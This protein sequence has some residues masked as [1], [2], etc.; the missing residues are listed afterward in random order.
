MSRRIPLFAIQSV[1]FI[2]STRCFAEIV[3]YGADD[4]A[5]SP[6]PP[7]ELSWA[8]QAE[9]TVFP[10]Y[11][12]N[13]E[14]ALGCLTSAVYY[15]AASEPTLGQEAVAQVVLNR[16]K[17]SNYP[18]SVCGVVYQGSTRRTGC[19]FTFTCDGS[20]ARQPVRAL[21][22]KAELVATRAL[23]GALATDFGPIT[24]YHAY[25]V[26]PYWS[27]SLVEV[28]RIGAHVFYQSPDSSPIQK[29]TMFDHEPIAVFTP[30]SAKRH[31]TSRAVQQKAS[32]VFST[33]GI[34]V[35]SIAMKN[36]TVAVH[37]SSTVL[38]AE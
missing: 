1:L 29:I 12:V 6:A 14:R 20:L 34:T 15:E 26:N 8:Q 31:R 36:G 13:R 32:S 33:W 37:Q 24:H 3:T 19:Q 21:W 30:H 38:K 5:L 22:Q 23:D 4:T 7:F 16:V 11:D 17:Q 28:A 18:K 25:W 2:M 35:A 10:V 27:S 9:D